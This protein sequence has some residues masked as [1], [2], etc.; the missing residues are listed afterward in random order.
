[1]KQNFVRGM[2]ILTCFLAMLVIVG[3]A[4]ENSAV[5][6]IELPE[7]NPTAKLKPGPGV[8]AVEANCTSCHSTDYIVRQPGGDT[9]RWQD[10]VNTMIKVFGA[11]VSDE[12]VKV[13]VNYLANSYGP[14]PAKPQPASKPTPG[15][16]SPKEKSQPR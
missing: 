1:M 13:V 14:A 11:T 6:T 7:D 9:Q 15:A 12:E 4:K 2:A 8:D 5:K 10:E 3:L 16:P